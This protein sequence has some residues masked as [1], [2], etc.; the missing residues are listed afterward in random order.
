MCLFHLSLR[1]IYRNDLPE[2]ESSKLFILFLDGNGGTDAAFFRSFCVNSNATVENLFQPNTLLYDIDVVDEAMM[3]KDRAEVLA[4]IPNLYDSYV[5]I[6][7][8]EISLTAKLLS[9]FMA[10]SLVKLR[11]ADRHVG[12]IIQSPAV[13]HLKT[14]IP[15]TCIHC[16]RHLLEIDSVDIFLGRFHGHFRF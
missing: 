12:N 6:A 10:A 5:T 1:K 2:N 7:S 11:S 15:I 4:N 3:W 9:K 14:S 16:G 13:K 8:F